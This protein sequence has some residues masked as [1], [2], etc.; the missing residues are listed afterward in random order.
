MGTPTYAIGAPYFPHMIIHLDNGKTIDI[1]APEVSDRNRYIQSMTLNGKPYD[2]SWLAHADLAE[3]AVLDFRMGAAPSKWGSE[4]GDARLPSLTMGT[5]APAPLIDL[6]DSKGAQVIVDGDD[7]AAHA[8]SDN[9][10]DT[11]AT[12]RGSDPVVQ[13]NLSQPQQVEMYTLTSSAKAGR[14]P[15]S[16][17]L[18]GSSDGIHWVVLDERRGEVFPSRRQTRA[19][20]VTHPGSYAHYRWRVNHAASQGVALSEMEW[21]GLPR[22]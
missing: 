4:P 19:F 1:R 14:D 2:R 16:W 11:E 6:A 12:L 13:L 7:A 15:E 5:A 18:E 8:L 10:S 21:L 3:G 9:T 22:S 20:G 17:K